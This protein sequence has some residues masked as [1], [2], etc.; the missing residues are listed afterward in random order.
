MNKKTYTVLF[1]IIST[2]FNIIMTL[3]IIVALMILVA[4]VYFKVL[5]AGVQASSALL[6]AW[7]ICFFGGLIVSMM[8]F[9]KICG[10]VI[11]K[12]HLASKL[13]PKVLGRYLPNGTKGAV[14]ADEPKRPKTN[15][16]KSPVAIDDEWAR[17]I[18]SGNSQQGHAPEEGKDD[19][20]DD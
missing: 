3:G 8:L 12:F 1:T 17:D 2:I 13:D 20:G 14:P 19:D 10:W 4:F 15:I 11:E 7:A 6:V 9:G 16:P 18:E 5:N